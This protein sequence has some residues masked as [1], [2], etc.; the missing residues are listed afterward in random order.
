LRGELKEAMDIGTKV[1]KI[2]ITLHLDKMALLIM[3]SLIEIM[4]TLEIPNLHLPS[5]RHAFILFVPIRL[6]QLWTKRIN[7]AVD[8]LR[9]LFFLADND[10]DLSAKTWYYA[11]CLELILDAGVIVESYKTSY[12]YY[13]K[14]KGERNAIT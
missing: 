14:F 4:V 9:Q 3:P 13:R 8:L 12:A 11:L 10:V 5:T 6:D 1:L 7:N 2:S